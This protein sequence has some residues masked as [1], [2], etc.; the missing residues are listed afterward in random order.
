M[1]S[2]DKAP[3]GAPC[4]VDLMTSDTAAS[5]AF[6]GELFGWTAEEPSE[7]FGGYFSFAKDGVLVAGCMGNQADSGQPDVWSVYLASEDAK[8][9]VD[10][11]AAN[12]GQVHVQAMDVADLGTMAIVG[13]PGGAAVGVWQ[14]GLHQGFGLLAQPG[15]PSWF[16]LHT[17]DYQPAIDFYRRVFGWTTETMSDTPEFHYTTMTGAEGPLAGVMDAT[18]FLPEGV[19][20]HWAVYFGVADTD[21]ALAKIVELG[22]S[23]VTP[24]EDTPYGR[25]ATA[26]DPTGAVFK[27]VAGTP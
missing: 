6:Y 4:W 26:A 11:T 1:P 10:D 12:G 2:R 21:A 20:A 9:T 7:Q 22:G 27:L 23:I 19:P 5:R 25:L 3:I 13:D 18:A 16:E 14:P 17:R 8:K 15:A 24:A